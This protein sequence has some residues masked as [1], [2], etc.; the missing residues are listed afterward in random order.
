MTPNVDDRK[1]EALSSANELPN[2]F[3]YVYSHVKT[4]PPP[5]FSL[6]SKISFDGIMNNRAGAGSAPPRAFMSDGI[7]LLGDDYD[8]SSSQF[9]GFSTHDH[10]RMMLRP[11][12]DQSHRSEKGRSSSF[13]DLAACL[14]EG[15]AES[16]GDSLM[17]KK[18][19]SKMSR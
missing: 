2:E 14:G 11:N 13:V 16:M 17:D 8:N 15:L 12:D 4:P 18:E 6:D 9:N 19:N 5:G 7:S 1:E 3:S 10:L